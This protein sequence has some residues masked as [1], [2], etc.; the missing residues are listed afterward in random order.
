METL[1]KKYILESTG[2]ST[3]VT[4]KISA[5]LREGGVCI[6][7]SGVFYVRGVDMPDGTTLMGMGK[8]TKIVLCAD[9][10][11]GHAVKLGSE[12][13]V[14]NLSVLGYETR[15]SRPT[16]V[17]KRHG[18]LFEGTANETSDPQPRNSIVESCFISSFEGGGITCVNTGY[19]TSSSI[20]ASN[21]HIMNCGAGINIPFFSEYHEFTNMLCVYNL[22]GCVN[23]GGNNTFVNCG[24]DS[25]TV[26]FLIDNSE[27]QSR[28]NSH[29]SVVG[30]TFNHSDSNKGI[31]IKVLGATYGYVF[32]ACQL[33]ASEVLV[34]NSNNILFSNFGFGDVN[35]KVSGGQLV[36]F[37][38]CVFFEE[39][40]LDVTENVKI[41]NC[42]TRYGSEVT[43]H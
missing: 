9:V 12:C 40:K 42:F 14:K 35:I 24:F 15:I 4:E 10:T 28:N 27:K 31:G 6:L 32:N 21:C 3:D 13:T 23:N 43:I 33:W 5:M 11:E 20:T 25:N 37:S 1:C 22:Y 18:I 30:C 7:G 2:D 39:P 36:M 8:A 26:G 41:V 16:E 19:A 17:G 34:E 29:G 38:S